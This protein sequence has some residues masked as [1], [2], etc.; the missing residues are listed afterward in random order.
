MGVVIHRAIASLGTSPCSAL[1]RCPRSDPSRPAAD[2]RITT[3]IGIRDKQDPGQVAV[4]GTQPAPDVG[5][6]RRKRG[7][8]DGRRVAHASPRCFRRRKHEQPSKA[9]RCESEPLTSERSPHYATPSGES[10][11]V[12]PRR[13]RSARRMRPMRMSSIGP[14]VN[15]GDLPPVTSRIGPPGRYRS[16]GSS[17]HSARG[18]PGSR[19]RPGRT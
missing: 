14:M 15:G 12:H 4:R 11:C 3:R 5:A 17:C 16:G 7:I 18:R 1:V 9:A 6:T 19:R 2:T 13:R 10:S 8:E